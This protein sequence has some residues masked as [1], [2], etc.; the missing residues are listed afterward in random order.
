[1]PLLAAAPGSVVRVVELR[2]GRGFQ[3]RMLEMGI[4]PGSTLRVVGS[5]GPVVVE[6]VNGGSVQR[7]AIG[8]GMAV[9]IYVEEVPGRA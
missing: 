4:G 9:K 6:V 2:G 1:M 8:R 3:R 5:W 7:V